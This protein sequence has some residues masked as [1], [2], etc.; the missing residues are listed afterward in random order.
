MICNASRDHYYA[1]VL[2]QS[3]LPIPQHGY[4][5]AKTL[6]SLG[7]PREKLRFIL[8]WLCDFVPYVKVECGRCG[9]M[10]SKAHL[11]SC[12]MQTSLPYAEWGKR[13]DKLL[14]K[15]I[16][17]LH[18]PSAQLAMSILDDEIKPAFPP[19]PNHF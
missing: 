6:H 15:A 14:H 8:F 4:T 2:T 1:T 7:I 9:Q 19:L 16:N 17:E 5:I 10:I 11:E 3:H 18:V 12:A 13:I